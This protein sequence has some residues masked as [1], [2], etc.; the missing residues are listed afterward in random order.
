MLRVCKVILTYIFVF[1][2]CYMLG[3]LQMVPELRVATALSWLKPRKHVTDE[4]FLCLIEL[5][6][7]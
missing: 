4:Y 7:I 1:V 3:L 5:E 6:I 2:K